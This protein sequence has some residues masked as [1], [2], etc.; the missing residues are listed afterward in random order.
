[1]IPGE[2]GRGCTGRG[3]GDGATAD[4]TFRNGD[5]GA[6]CADLGDGCE[7]TAAAVRARY[8]VVG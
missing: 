1:M 4:V 3:N 7:N 2:D 6:W 8:G 5:G